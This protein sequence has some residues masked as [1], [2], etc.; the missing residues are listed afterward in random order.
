MARSFYEQGTIGRIGQIDDNGYAVEVE[1]LKG[2]LK[3]YYIT[4]RNLNGLVAWIGF[5]PNAVNSS[6]FITLNIEDDY[7]VGWQ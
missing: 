3:T 6:P 5:F 4:K 2:E 7:I 1:T